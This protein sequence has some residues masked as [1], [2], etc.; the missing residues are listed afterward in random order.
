MYDFLSEVFKALSNPVRLKIIELLRD[1]PRCGCEIWPALDEEQ[2]NVSKHLN[3]LKRVGIIDSKKDGV[4]V[5][6]SI[7][8]PKIL[9]ILKIAK[10][11]VK[12]EIENKAKMTLNL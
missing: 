9:E 7:K 1:E 4:K 12:K 5:I 11:I 8:N 10:E 6:F 3:E 2:S